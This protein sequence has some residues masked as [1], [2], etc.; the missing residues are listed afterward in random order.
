M[1]REI[2][3]R[4][5]TLDDA[6]TI[7]DIHC[8]SWQT[9]Y[10]GDF[11][12]E[13]LDQEAPTERLQVWRERLRKADPGMVLELATLGQEVVGFSCVFLDHHETF[14]HLLDNLHVRP[15]YYGKGIGKALLLRSMKRVAKLRGAGAP[16]YLWVLEN[17][18]QAIG[19][20]ERLRGR[21]GELETHHFPGGNT[22]RAISYHWRAR[23]TAP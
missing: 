20:Y 6:A 5:G 8:R 14:G 3:F 10:R 15:G 12:D 9:H 11:T 19:F 4:P 13:Y 7:A 1:S 2:S 16:Y 21:R 18:A 17:N 22:V 23:E